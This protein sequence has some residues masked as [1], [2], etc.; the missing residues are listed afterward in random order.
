MS[1]IKGSKLFRET[2]RILERKLGVLED[3]EVACCGIT[4]AQ[5]HALV[6]IG[7]MQTISLGE[8]AQMLDLDSSTL[9]RT[10][11]NLVTS[12]LASREAD[13]GDRR[14]ITISLTDKGRELFADV[15]NAMDEYFDRIFAQIPEQKRGQILEDLIL[16][17]EAMDKSECC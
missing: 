6:E 4:M 16:I 12:G 1:N 3:G 11:N 14:F 8:L 17:I 9:S 15:E 5:C 10:V 2:V 13:P 7:R